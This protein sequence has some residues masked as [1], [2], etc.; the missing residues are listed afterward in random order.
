MNRVGVTGFI[1]LFYS[2][3]IW[4]FATTEQKVALIDRWILLRSEE[5]LHFYIVVG[6][7][8]ILLAVQQFHYTSVLGQNQKRIDELA[9]AK[10]ELQ[11]KGLRNRKLRSSNSGK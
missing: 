10:R 3:F 2:V 1:V 4:V 6:C 9:E 5:N 11:S 7:L 8:L